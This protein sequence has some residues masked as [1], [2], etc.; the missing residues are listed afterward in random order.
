MT[1]ENFR[2]YISL[3]FAYVAVFFIWLTIHVQGDVDR[4]EDDYL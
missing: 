1:M 2:Y 4:F 3:P